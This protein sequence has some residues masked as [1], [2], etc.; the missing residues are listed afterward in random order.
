[1]KC[2]FEDGCISVAKI[3]RSTD[4]KKEGQKKGGSLK[5]HVERDASGEALTNMQVPCEKCGREQGVVRPGVIAWLNRC[6][7]RD[8]VRQDSYARAA[9]LSAT[10]FRA[11]KDCRRG[12]Q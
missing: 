3:S 7:E 9:I 12:G 2:W 8:M 4:G 6:E 10:S 5:L 11:A 1:M